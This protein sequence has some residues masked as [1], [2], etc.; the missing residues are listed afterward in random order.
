VLL[1]TALALHDLHEIIKPQH[2]GPLDHPSSSPSPNA[3]MSPPSPTDSIGDRIRIVPPTGQ[4]GVRREAQEL[5]D[6]ATPHRTM[7][8]PLPLQCR[9]CMCLLLRRHHYLRWACPAEHRGRWGLDVRWITLVAASMDRG[10]GW[11]DR[12]SFK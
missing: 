1:F 5:H 2:I 8:I 11:V 7:S 12:A 4:S 9:G 6:L 3:R 10:G